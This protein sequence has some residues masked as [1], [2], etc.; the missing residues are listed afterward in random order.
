MFCY[1]PTEAPSTLHYAGEICKRSFISMV[2][3]YP[4]KLSTETG[5]FRKRSSN[6]RN[7]KSAGF[8]LNGKYFKNGA[9]RKRRRHKNHMINLN[10]QG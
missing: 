3:L 4:E 5:A 10:P 2:K 7:L 9:F 6:Q 8:V 1:N